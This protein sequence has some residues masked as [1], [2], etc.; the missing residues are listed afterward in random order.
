MHIKQEP[1]V[2]RDPVSPLVD[3]LAE[4]EQLSS[5]FLLPYNL[6]TDDPLRNP[7]LNVAKP[8]RWRPLSPDKSRS[9]RGLLARPCLPGSFTGQ[10]AVSL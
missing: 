1:Q 4:K 2:S 8:F 9:L 5:S 6:S 3:V 7:C 10:A